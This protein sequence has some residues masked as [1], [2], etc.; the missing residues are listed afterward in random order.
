MRLWQTEFVTPLPRAKFQKWLEKQPGRQLVLVRYST[1]PEN[2][3]DYAVFVFKKLR[4]DTGWV[5][6]SSDL[7]TAKVVW[8]RELDPESNQALLK[9]FPDRTVW[10]AEPEQ[11]PA[12]LRLYPNAAALRAGNNLHSAK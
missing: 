8:A 2:S 4:E 10:L 3:R 7:N 11:D 9:Q 1:L 5:Y 6:N 12:R